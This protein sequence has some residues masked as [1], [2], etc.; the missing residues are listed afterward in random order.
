MV[1]DCP[2]IMNHGKYLKCI[3]MQSTVSEVNLHI[4]VS[5]TAADTAESRL[6]SCVIT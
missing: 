6:L 4:A 1:N 5:N 3:A 2:L